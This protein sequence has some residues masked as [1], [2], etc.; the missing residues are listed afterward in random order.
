MRA[1]PEIEVTEALQVFCPLGQQKLLVVALFIVEKVG[2]QKGFAVAVRSQSVKI[3]GI[4]TVKEDAVVATVR[5][6]VEEV[7]DSGA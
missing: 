7:L 2:N 4:H 3:V 6:P 5:R 1:L